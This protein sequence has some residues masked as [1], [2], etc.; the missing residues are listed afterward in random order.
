MKGMHEYKP[1]SISLWGAVA[2]GTGVM[3]GAGIFALTGQVAELAGNAFPLVFLVAA[4]VTAFS[5][6]SY[7]KMSNAYP[8][9]GGIAMILQKAYGRGL[10][11]AVCSLLMALSMVINEALVARTFGTYSIQLFGPTNPDIWVP[12]LAVLLLI[13]AFLINVSGNK[14]VSAVSIALS[15]IKIL[16]IAILAFAGLWIAGGIGGELQSLKSTDI[17]EI[18]FL[19]ALAPAIL[20]YKGFTTITNSGGEVVEPHR[21]VGR[22]IIISLAICTIIYLLVSLAVGANLN[23]AEIIAARDFA[24]AQAARPALGNLGLT[25]TVILAVIAT[26]SGVIASIFAV[27]RMLTM[28]TE[29]KLVPHSHFGMKGPL[30]FH[31]LVYTVVIAIVLTVF[32]DLTRIASLGAILYLVMDIAIHWGILRYMRKEVSANPVILVTAILLDVVVLAAFL[33]VKAQT[34]IAI[35]WMAL[36]TLVAVIGMEW[37]FLR[38][39]TEQTTSTH[40][41][42]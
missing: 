12:A 16:G 40:M 10:V 24:L 1:N 9:A 19:A 32:L 15:A 17:A 11:A 37:W 18:G 42:H 8:S 38:T 5:A 4:I 21:N 6:Y 3:I 36:A 23:L 22:A 20:A 41:H 26:A 14:T 2:L 25:L 27:S 29:M 39:Q 13:V 31:L 7:I 34:D 35:I 28:L 33:I 30:K